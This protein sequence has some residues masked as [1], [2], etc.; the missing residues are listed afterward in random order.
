MLVVA[1]A[2]VVEAAASRKE[3][4]EDEDDDDEEKDEVLCGSGRGGP[5]RW[6]STTADNRAHS[7]SWK[8]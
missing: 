1:I 2:V 6:A 3:E 7:S 5:T 8:V 4:V